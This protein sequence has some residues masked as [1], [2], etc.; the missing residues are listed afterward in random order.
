[1]IMAIFKAYCKWNRTGAAQSLLLG[2]LILTFLG[3]DS[4]NPAAVYEERQGRP[5]PTIPAR[6]A[7]RRQAVQPRQASFEAPREYP[8][9]TLKPGKVIRDNPDP[10]EAELK[11]L[12][13]G[14][15]I[16]NGMV[17][18]AN[19][20]P[21][22]NRI[23]D[24]DTTTLYKTEGVNPIVLA[25]TFKEPIALKTI[26]MFPSYSSYDWAVYTDD[27]E[28]GTIIRSVPEETWS[29]MDFEKSVQTNKV[30]VEVLRLERDNF[31][32]LNEVEM[33]VQ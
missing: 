6:I 28:K 1:M 12:Q 9:P 24:G 15:M 8:R 33:Y 2:L 19:W 22:H 5:T 4:R 10:I 16:E 18:V 17:T 21:D 11:P 30:R 32:H 29:R 27:T 7:Q 14:N 13:L 3:C 26:R 23:V 25:F 31:V 20:S